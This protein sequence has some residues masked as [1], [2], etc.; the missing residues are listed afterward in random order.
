MIKADGPA[1]VK[2]RLLL[3]SL[4]KDALILLAAVFPL[5][6]STPSFAQ[7]SEDEVQKMEEQEF[8]L[9]G[10]QKAKPRQVQV[11]TPV[12][13]N[14]L[15]KPSLPDEQTG[16]APEPIRPIEAEEFMIKPLK[17]SRTGRVILFEDPAENRPRPGK[18]LLLKS[19]ND[20]VLAVR[21]LKNYPGRFAAKAVLT[22]K[23][24]QLNNEYRALKKLGNKI[25]AL[26]KEKEERDRRGKNLN[27]NK[28]DEDLAKEVA[29]DDNELDR[30]IPLPKPKGKRP[31]A[32]VSAPQTRAPDM[33]EPLFSKDGE[34]LG[35]SSGGDALEVGDEDGG[36]GDLSIRE[37]V[38]LEPKNHAVSL[39]YA[40]LR[41]IDKDKNAASYSGFGARYAY[42]FWR[43]PF[44]KKK[45]L[46]DLMS[47]ELGLFY[48]SITGFASTDDSVT[49]YPFDATVRYNL[50][51][52]DSFS[53]FG[54]LG[55]VKNFVK[56]ADNPSTTT[57]ATTAATDTT[58]LNT[59]KASI[60]I[61][62]MLKIGPS[63]AI[64]VEY[65][66]DLFGVGAVLKF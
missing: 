10:G 15:E 11:E 44:I 33:P 56:A 53:A 50:L 2:E 32:P 61:G 27:E 45:T 39:E 66:T 35:S 46:Q 65:G 18:V 28:T 25:I 29:P 21:V 54:Y 59:T 57:P 34:E 13:T 1:K 22:F 36:Y 62:A 3:N 20:D 40:S 43:S 41:S 47:V 6:L 23:E 16:A 37:D 60:G 63:W 30:G 17:K 55:F 7:V 14:P 49:V 31:V 52:G 26:I 9:D 8:G 64:R 4:R 12:Q 5:V 38:P 19:G 42:N 48:Y 58:V 24:L 51:F